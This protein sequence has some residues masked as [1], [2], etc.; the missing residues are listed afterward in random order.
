MVSEFAI[1]IMA[2]I[3]PLVVTGLILPVQFRTHIKE[4]PYKIG[5][6]LFS[7]IIVS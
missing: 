1:N 5:I 6:G 3:W 4:Q 2:L 7:K